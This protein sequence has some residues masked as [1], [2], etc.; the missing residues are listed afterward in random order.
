MTESREIGGAR[1][2]SAR[3][4]RAD[5]VSS[6]E[7]GGLVGH[8]PGSVSLERLDHLLLLVSF[9]SVG[10][11]LGGINYRWTASWSSVCWVALLALIMQQFYAKILEY[12]Q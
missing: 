8:A 2:R 5:S 10:L 7:G 11:E 6:V 9:S 1:G 3:S 12:P 4:G